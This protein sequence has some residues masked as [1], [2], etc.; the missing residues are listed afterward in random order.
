MVDQEFFQVAHSTGSRTPDSLKLVAATN[1]ALR[2]LFVTRNRKLMRLCRLPRLP[3]TPII[4]RLKT[5]E[6]LRLAIT[7]LVNNGKALL[8]QSGLTHTV[9]SRRFQQ[10]TDSTN[11]HLSEK[12]CCLTGADRVVSSHRATCADIYD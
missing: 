11:A 7:Q 5:T 12:C 3:E 8:A 6:R 4:G 2:I 1:V 10:R 9:P